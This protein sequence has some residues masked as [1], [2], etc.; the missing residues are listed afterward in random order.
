MEISVFG[1]PEISKAVFVRIDGKISLPLIGDVQ[2]ADITATVLAKTISEKLT[3]FVGNPNVTVILAESRSKVY[4][5]LGQIKTPGEYLITQPITILQAIGRAG[6]LSEWAK[7]SKI[8]IVSK[9]GGS[10]KINYFDYDAFL[11]GENIGQ[12]VT[13]NPGDT[14]VIP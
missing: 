1:E 7:K 5:V 10:K 14:I 3:K 2:A 9:P 4:Y 11:A 6:G 13:I 12:N 8:M